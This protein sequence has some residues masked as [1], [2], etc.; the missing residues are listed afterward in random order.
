MEIVLSVA[1]VYPHEMQQGRIEIKSN[2]SVLADAPAAIASLAGISGRDYIENAKR[3]VL[4][5][6]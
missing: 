4:V 6:P 1:G 3:P 5:A 2:S